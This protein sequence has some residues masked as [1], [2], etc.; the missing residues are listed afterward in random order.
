MSSVHDLLD[1]AYMLSWCAQRQS[2]AQPNQA[3]TMKTTQQ[4]NLYFSVMLKTALLWVAFGGGQALAANPVSADDAKILFL[5]HSVG[6]H[7]QAEWEPSPY[8]GNG[9]FSSNL[10]KHNQAHNKRY[11]YQHR[12]YP[13]INFSKKPKKAQHNHAY[14][15]DNKPF[16]YWDM[17]DN[18]RNNNTQL[19]LSNQQYMPQTD[20]F[21][22]IVQSA[23]L[24]I[25]KHC[26]TESDVAADTGNANP[27][28]NRRT[29]EIYKAQYNAL[30][31]K[32]R[33][34]PNTK[35]LVW[36]LPPQLAKSGYT[37]AQAQRAKAFATWVKTQWDEPGDNIFIFDFRALAADQDHLFLPASRARK[38]GD[39]HP[40]P[41]FNYQAVLNF[42]QRTVDVLEG[43]GD[44]APLTGL[45]NLGSN[46]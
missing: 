12:L 28:Q 39:N 29:L 24:I 16:V 35:F 26:Y 27:N 6:N 10:A 1:P 23:D 31:T 17:W 3:I 19:D 14:G 43:R 5:H 41:D 44:T 22:S 18:P 37:K 11:R 25:F 40:N 2:A 38:A 33:S 30:K 4:P 36:T 32:M 21:D 20:T 45:K 15:W 13:D 46:E 42:V 34:E 7:V 8:S 9:S